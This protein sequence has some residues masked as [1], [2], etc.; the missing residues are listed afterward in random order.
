M[1]KIIHKEIKD[2]ITIGETT[3]KDGSKGPWP[4]LG[5]RKLT[6]KY[7]AYLEEEIG[8]PMCLYG[9]P[10]HDGSTVGQI[11]YNQGALARAKEDLKNAPEVE[12]EVE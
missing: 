4:F 2:V 12:I 5:G 10:F 7:I 3:F 9:K 11:F 6:T 8:M 1:A